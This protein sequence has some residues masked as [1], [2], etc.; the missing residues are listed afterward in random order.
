M[1]TAL[2]D[3]EWQVAG[4]DCPVCAA[5]LERAC[6]GLP[7]VAQVK[8]DAASGRLRVSVDPATF[9]FQVFA[10]AARRAGHPIRHT[11]RSGRR[12]LLYPLLCGLALAAGI[13]AEAALGRQGW[14]YAPATACGVVPLLPRAFAALRRA[15]VDMNVL[16][17]TAMLGALG[18]GDQREA[19]VLAFLFALAQALERHS[20]GTTGRAVQSLLELAPRTA[21]VERD[22]EAREVPVEDVAVGERVRLRPGDLVPLDGTIVEGR[23]DLDEAVVT[24]ES[25]PLAKSPGDQ[26][27]AATLVLDGALTVEVT[28]RA[29]DSTLA[30][31]VRLVEQAEREPSPTAR[32]VDRFAAWYT[33]L[34]VGLAALTIGAGL[35]LGWPVSEAVYRGLVLLVIGCPCALVIATPV[36]VYSGLT[37]AAR[38]GALVRGGEPLEALA[39]LRAVAFDKTGTLT[40]GRPRLVEVVALE[41]ARDAA[42]AL[43]AALEAE[44][45]HPLARAVV[46][47]AAAEGLAFEAAAAHRAHPGLGVS[48]EVA[49][50]T[51]HLGSRRLLESA[52]IDP[53]AADEAASRL[54]E[55]GCGAMILSGEHPLAVL[56]LRD[57]PRPEAAEAVAALAEV[58]M[59]TGDHRATA[60][61]VGHEIGLAAVHAELLPEDKQALVRELTARHGVTAMVGD[62]INDA[63]ALAAA[64]V[65]IAL[66]AVGSDIAVETAD[67]ALLGDDLRALPRLIR[68]ARRVRRTIA[69][70]LA[71]AIVIR[72]VLVPLAIAGHAGLALAILGDMGGSLLVTGNSL[73]I[74]RER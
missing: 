41:G 64:T 5:G 1:N 46:A 17:A 12:E 49:G 61:A 47:T 36:A 44:S 62:G 29:E 2:E 10:A 21:R 66:G 3:R 48:G 22:G 11:E 65:G 14:W 24:G 71:I 70:N 16:M 43:A 20:L 37:A 8:A 32:L 31:V 72:L 74:L 38:R 55:Q 54:E 30:R 67:V 7:G 28:R 34:V 50:Q 39:Q 9:D 53:A 69:A 57:A 63:P 23:S 59:L 6:E 40:A 35:A 45:S 18:L 51:Y 68:L 52:G 56:A 19:A 15:A 42:L 58:A 13:A 60:E 33:P 4:L 73:R 26:V 25:T 27:Y